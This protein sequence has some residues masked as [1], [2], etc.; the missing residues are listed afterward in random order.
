ME[1][2]YKC[3]VFRTRESFQTVTLSARYAATNPFS[4][5]AFYKNYFAERAIFFL[6]IDLTIDTRSINSYV[7]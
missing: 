5:W 7:L 2:L 1:R 6:N 4:R 3:P